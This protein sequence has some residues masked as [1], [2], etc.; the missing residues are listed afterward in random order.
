MEVKVEMVEV[1]VVEMV[2][3]ESLLL[4]LRIPYPVPLKEQPSSPLELLHGDER[5][6]QSR[7]K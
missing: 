3:V 7:R 1:E 4:N 2:E 5:R 6:R